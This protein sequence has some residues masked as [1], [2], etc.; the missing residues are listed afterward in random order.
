MMTINAPISATIMDHQMPF[1]PTSIGN[2][3]TAPTWKISTRDTEIMA[4][5]VPL[6]RAV[7]KADPKP[8]KPP[9]TK[10]SA[11][12]EKAYTV[13]CHSAGSLLTKRPVIG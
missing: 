4:D 10:D 13:S 1:I 12:T 3:H 6:L 2:N 9:M 11:Y 7:K 8:L 5:T